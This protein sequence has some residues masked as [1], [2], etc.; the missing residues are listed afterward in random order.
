[1]VHFLRGTQRRQAAGH[2]LKD[3]VSC[4]FSLICPVVFN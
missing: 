4:K 2:V 3:V 1:M